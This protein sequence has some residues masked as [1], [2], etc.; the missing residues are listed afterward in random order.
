VFYSCY[1]LYDLAYYRRL[2]F[3]FNVIGLVIC[4]CETFVIS[5][6]KYIQ[7]CIF[8]KIYHRNNIAKWIFFRE[9]IFPVENNFFFHI[10]R[11]GQCSQKLLEG[12]KLYTHLYHCFLVTCKAKVK[13]IDNDKKK[14]SSSCCLTNLVLPAYAF[15]NVRIQITN[16]DLE[17][18]WIMF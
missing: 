10:S 18:I 4:I 9:G 6:S 11:L 14:T 5:A 16:T 12:L 2:N 8:F 17:F 1:N 7:M 15:Q 13:L 3:F